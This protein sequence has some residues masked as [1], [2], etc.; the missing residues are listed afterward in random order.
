VKD[1]AKPSRLTLGPVVAVATAIVLIYQL[2]LLV[3][4]PDG[5]ILGLAFSAMLATVWMAIRILKDPYTT[6]KTFDDYFYQDRE[7]LRRYG[8]E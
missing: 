7:D 1:K 6:D 8:K 5:M 3:G 2:S 4:V